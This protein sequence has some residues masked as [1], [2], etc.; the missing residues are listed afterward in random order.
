MGAG[1]DARL[2]LSNEPGNRMGLE[3]QAHTIVEPFWESP[4]VS[5]SVDDFGASTTAL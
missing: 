1:I 3:F 5:G 4:A 2:F